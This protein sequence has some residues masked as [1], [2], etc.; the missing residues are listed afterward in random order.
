MAATAWGFFNKAKKLLAQ[1]TN[2][3]RLDSA[4]QK[5]K[6]SLHTSAVFSTSASARAYSLFS[7]LGNEIVAQGGYSAGG[8][9]LAGV[10]WTLQGDPGSVKWDATDLVFTA[11]GANLSNIKFAIIHVSAGSVTSGYPLCWSRLS[12]SQFSVTSGNTLTIQF[13]AAG[14]FTLT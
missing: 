5:F 2:G 7:A 3:I 8:R 4:T 9:T 1:E 6:M 13:A 10:A 12:T 14:I 11:N